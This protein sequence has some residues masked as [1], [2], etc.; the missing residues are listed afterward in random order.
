MPSGDSQSTIVGSVLSV[1]GCAYCIYLVFCI[2]M[3]C[4]AL[5]LPQEASPFRAS[6]RT[7]PAMGTGHGAWLVAGPLSHHQEHEKETDEAIERLKKF[8]NGFMD[9]YGGK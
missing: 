7:L 9:K 5:L 3:H 6:S 4:I 8:H 2:A 1:A